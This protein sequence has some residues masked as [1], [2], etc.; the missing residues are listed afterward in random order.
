MLY[1]DAA[2]DDVSG[3]VTALT[4]VSTDAV[5]GG[6][7][8]GVVVPLA[9]GGVDGGGAVDAALLDQAGAVPLAAGAGATFVAGGGNIRPSVINEEILLL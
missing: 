8:S 4:A 5:A 1:G 6:L 2:A 3:V 7:A 9:V